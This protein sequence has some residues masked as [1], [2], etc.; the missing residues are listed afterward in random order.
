MCKTNVCVCVLPVLA[1]E[2]YQHIRSLQVFSQLNS[3]GDFTELR[4]MDAYEPL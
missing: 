3:H 2:A 1:E 4:R